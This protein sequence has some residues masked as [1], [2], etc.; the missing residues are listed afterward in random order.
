MEDVEAPSIVDS[1]LFCQVN[2]ILLQS[3]QL[4]EPTMGLYYFDDYMEPTLFLEAKGDDP[5]TYIEKKVMHIFLKTNIILDPKVVYRD[6]Y[7][8]E[9]I[10]VPKEVVST[11]YFGGLPLYD[12]IV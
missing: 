7:N 3:M 12:A 6:H 4:D 5:T 11:Y 10:K 9:Y 8:I 2:S 1:N